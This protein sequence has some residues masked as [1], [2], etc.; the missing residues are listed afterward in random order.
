MEG[1]VNIDDLI[2]HKL[3]LEEINKGFDLMHAGESIRSVV[4]F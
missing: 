3:K 1:R 4:E 2:T